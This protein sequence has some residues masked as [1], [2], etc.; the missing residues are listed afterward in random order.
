MPFQ[1]KSFA[2]IVRGQINHARSVT[3]KITDFQPG[4]VVRTIMEAP[5]VEIEELYMQMFLGLRDAIP[6]ATFRSFQFDR[7]PAAR[8][9]GF[10]SISSPEPIDDDILIMAGTEFSAADGR[11]YRAT[12]FTVWDKGTTMVRVPV[13]ATTIGLAGNAAEG[14][15]TSSPAFSDPFVV[16]NPPIDTGRDEETDR[17]R[18]ARFADF[19]RSLS[20]GT[21]VACMYAARQ[22]RVL[23]DDGFINEYVTRSGLNEQPG[24]VRIYLYSSRGVPTDTLI[25]DGQRRIDGWVDEVT[26]A[27]TPGFRPA[28]VRVDILPMIERVIDATFSVAMLPGQEFT[29]SV[30]QRISDVFATAVRN[31]MPGEVL[32]IGTLV[33]LMLSVQ[34]VRSIVPAVN[35]NIVCGVNEALIPGELTLN[36]L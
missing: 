3:E 17:E 6:V 13:E 10:V 20:R 28:G 8:A 4:S 2:D 24:H 12:G 11:T 35:E 5:A 1:I 33:E 29:E 14:V 36:P 26:G 16:S 22:A 32:Q 19:I 7:L 34:G 9:Q 25:A 15:I 30:K 18:E 23:E 27:I 21:V 31:V